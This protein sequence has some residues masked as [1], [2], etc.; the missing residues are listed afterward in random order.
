[1]G[2]QGGLTV[3]IAAV[4]FS[5]VV[6]VAAVRHSTVTALVGVHIGDRCRLG[7]LGWVCLRLCSW[8][9]QCG[10]KHES[11]DGNELGV[12]HLD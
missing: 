12:M 10:T 6:G 11:R 4:E 8:S 5:A 7:W 9:S 1:M 3:G 2:A